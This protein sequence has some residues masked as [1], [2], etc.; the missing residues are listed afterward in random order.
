MAGGD[1]CYKVPAYYVQSGD[2]VTSIIQN[3]YNVATVDDC[4]LGAF[5]GANP[6]GVAGCAITNCEGNLLADA[7]VVLPTSLYDA[8]TGE[9]Y[10][11]GCAYWV[12]DPTPSGLVTTTGSCDYYPCGGLA[13]FADTCGYGTVSC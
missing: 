5:I 9:T 1:P 3:F 12:S 4:L 2:T 6:V 10:S 8:Y 11:F 13:T 7:W